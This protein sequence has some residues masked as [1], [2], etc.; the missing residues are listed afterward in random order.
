MLLNDP[1]VAHLPIKLPREEKKQTPISKQTM[2]VVAPKVFDHFVMNLP[3]TAVDFL[4]DF[5]GIYAGHEDMFQPHGSFMLPFIHCYCFG[6]KTEDDDKDMQ[7]AEDMIWSLI[8]SRLGTSIDLKSPGT[9]LFD[10][11]DVAPNKRQ[12]CASFRLPAAAAFAKKGAND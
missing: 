9:E 3:A 4:P 6:P 10:V 7:V 12:F 1:P 5:I 2:K 8:S 11:R